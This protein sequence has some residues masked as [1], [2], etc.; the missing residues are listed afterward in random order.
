MV[1]SEG[2]EWQGREDARPC[3]LLRCARCC[4]AHAI[5]KPEELT[6]IQLTFRLA[7]IAV[8]GRLWLLG[9]LGIDLAFVGTV[10]IALVAV[11]VSGFALRELAAAGRKG[12]RRMALRPA[13]GAM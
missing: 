13:A 1:L 3:T 12:F 8:A 11:T 9:P 10:G 2:A 4:D 7:A 6:L 5:R